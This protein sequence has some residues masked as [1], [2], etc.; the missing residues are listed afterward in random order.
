M[1]FFNPTVIGEFC[2][3][4]LQKKAP[5]GKQ[6]CY[7]IGAGFTNVVCRLGITCPSYIQLFRSNIEIIAFTL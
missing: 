1:Q 6:R 3:S 7:N 5:A 4:V 2:C